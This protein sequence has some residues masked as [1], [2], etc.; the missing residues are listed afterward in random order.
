MAYSDNNFATTSSLHHHHK[1]SF[2][3]NTNTSSLE[4]HSGNPYV[5]PWWVE[6]GY[7]VVYLLMVLIAVGGNLVVI[8][9]VVGNRRMRTVTNYFLVNLAVCDILITVFNTMFNF[10][11]MCRSHWPFGVLYCKF[12]SFVVPCTIT[13]SVFT[14][15][16]IAID[17]WKLRFF[18]LTLNSFKNGFWEFYFGH[19]LRFWKI[20]LK[21]MQNKSQKEKKFLIY[22]FWCRQFRSHCFIKRSFD[23]SSW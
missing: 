23:Q 16:A 12:I 1:I 4:V 8:W 6:T 17:R 13:A 5:M 2:K 22:F 21:I 20:F 15:I 7:A 11:Y 10:I 14:F 9:V 19:K 18:S 3:N